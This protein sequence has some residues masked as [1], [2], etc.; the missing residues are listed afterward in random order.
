MLHLVTT[1]VP[2]QP[3]GIEPVASRR[4]PDY[5]GGGTFDHF[6]ELSAQETEALKGKG[7]KVRALSD[8][9]YE[10]D[11]GGVAVWSDGRFWELRSSCF[12][13]VSLGGEGLA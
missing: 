11:A 7:L 5:A 9:W 8:G 12:D 6:C 10:L 2:G 4:T 13:V 3:E 1:S